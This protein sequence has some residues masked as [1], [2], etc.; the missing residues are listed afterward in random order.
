ML[1][2]HIVSPVQC[3][4]REVSATA[5]LIPS[6]CLWWWGRVILGGKGGGG[7]GADFLLLLP[8]Q[9]VGNHFV[10]FMN[11]LSTFL[12]R[13]PQCSVLP[14]SLLLMSQEASVFRLKSFG[15]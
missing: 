2:T 13:M 5:C 8:L 3:A 9:R 11:N 4:W 14:G 10:L 12:G 6:S 15:Q 7:G 1:Y